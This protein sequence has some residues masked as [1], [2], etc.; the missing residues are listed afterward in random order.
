MQQQLDESQW[1]RPKQILGQ[2]LRQ[3][4]AQLEHAWQH[5]PFYR[6]RLAT[7]GFV[8]G[9]ALTPEIWARIPVL[10]RPVLQAAGA[11]L[12]S[13]EILR[14]HGHIHETSTS[15]STGRPVK[16]R[17]TALSQFMWE[18]ITLREHSWHRR[19]FA[20]ILAAIRAFPQGKAVYPRGAQTARW[21]LAMDG[22][23]QTGPA[24]VLSVVSRTEQQAEWLQRVRPGYLLTYPS[25]LRELLLHCRDKRIDLPEL[26]EVRTFAEVLP[27][28]TRD[29]CRAVWGLKIVDMYST[30]ENGYLA[31]QCPER[32]HYHVQSEAVLLEVLNE[33]GEVCKP[34]EVG[35]V[36]TTPLLNYAMPLIRYAVGDLAEVGAPCAC[37]R[38]LPVLKRILGRT[39]DMLVYPDGRKAWPLIGEQYYT[40]IPDVRQFQIVQH[41]VDDIELKLV[42]GRRLTKEEESTLFEA[43][44]TRCAHAFPMR[45]TYHREIPRSASG[46]YQDFRC[47][48]LQNGTGK[49][50]D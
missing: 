5:V 15:G 43:F 23:Y 3:A 19:D 49:Q 11:A 35:H 1:L 41:A 4:G 14:S 16:V 33:A 48:V 27:A 46:K 42:A 40:E 25:A 9:C 29:L 8:P 44:R 22:L 36:V 18:A 50:G 39:R 34:G 13:R 26:R 21:G 37:G 6:D 38:G 2:Q 12:H 32:E 31:L 45:V 20:G 17:G 10:T 28:A 30:Q 24:A 7:A 47:E